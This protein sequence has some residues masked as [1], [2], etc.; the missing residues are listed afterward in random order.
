[1]V[2]GVQGVVG[3]VATTTRSGRCTQ[4]TKDEVAHY[5]DLMP[6]GTHR[7][8]TSIQE[9][10]SVITAPSGGQKLL[11]QGYYDI[12]GLAWSGRGSVERV[13]VSVDGGRHW[14]EARLEG[15]ILPKALPGFTLIGFGRVMRHYCSPGSPTAPAIS[16]PAA[17]SWSQRAAR[18]RSTTTT[19][20]RR[21]ESAATERF[22]MS[23]WVKFVM[24]L[25]TAMVSTSWVMALPEGLE[26]LG[27]PATE[28]EVSAGY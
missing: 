19:L 25:L 21:G 26:A 12:T 7:Q 24:L 3:Q 2:P 16:S 18:D 15:P 1:M 22:T 5:V 6:D 4:A 11:K 20:S 23:S 28:G 17:L 10:K 9:A 14:R 27:R 13:E 8:Y